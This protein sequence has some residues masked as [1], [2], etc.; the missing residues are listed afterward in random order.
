MVEISDQ[1][2]QRLQDASEFA[3]STIDT[4]REPLIV[5]DG[6][7]K[8]VSASSSFYKT[9]KVKP[10]E[11]ERQ[12]IYN[13]G[14]NQ[15]DIPDLRKLLENILLKSECFDNYE[16]DHDFPGIGRRVMLLNARRI[17]RPPA[18]PRVILLAIEDISERK[19]IAQELAKKINDL[20]IFFH[21]SMGREDRIIE[22]KTEINALLKELGREAEY[23]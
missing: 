13:L 1:E 11:T 21:T 7:L 5:L 20:E 16:V 10:E 4:V 18:K 9:F 19:R 8:V 6:D 17:P 3:E 12:F 15:W 22:L 2:Y 23:A 14:N